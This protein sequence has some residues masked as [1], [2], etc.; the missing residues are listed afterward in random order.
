MR[1]F[2]T[3]AQVA[4][5]QRQLISH[6]YDVALNCIYDDATERAV[7]LIQRDHGLLADGIAGSKTIAMLIDPAD[8]ASRLAE[9]DAR[10]AAEQLDVPLSV[11]KALIE[12]MSSGPGLLE[13]G[14]ALIVYERHVAFTLVQ[15]A[16]GD[17][18]AKALAAA[19]PNLF[20]EQPGGYAGLESEWARLATAKQ[21]LDTRFG[22][23]DIAEESCLWG[24]FRILGSQW[25][26]LGY[27]SFAEFRAAMCRSEGA[28]LDAFARLIA[29]DPALLKALKARKWTEF[30][31]LIAGPPY[32]ER[33]IDVRLARAFD[34]YESEVFA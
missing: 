34:R 9:G 24:E 11:V 21:V 14:R 28:Q 17:D 10:G 12:V 26:A 30:A 7:Y 31:R 20:S 25:N 33:L 27:D 2:D 23:S 1:K 4:A 19:H 15:L 3:G 18:D 29:S 5:L 6:G 13:D 22:P 8:S 16:H 32:K